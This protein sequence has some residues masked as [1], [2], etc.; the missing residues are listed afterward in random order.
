MPSAIATFTGDERDA[1]RFATLLAAR[2]RWRDRGHPRRRRRSARRS[3]AASRPL[4]GGARPWRPGR[5]PAATVAATRNRTSTG[6]SRALVG[7][8]R[9][10]ADLAGEHL[11]GYASSAPRPGPSSWLHDLAVGERE[12]DHVSGVAR[13]STSTG[14]PGATSRSSTS[15]RSRRRAGLDGGREPRLNSR[16]TAR[17]S[18]RRGRRAQVLAARADP[19][20]R[21]GARRARVALRLVGELPRL[22]DLRADLGELDL[23]EPLALRTSL[24]SS[25]PMRRSAADLERQ[26][27]ISSRFRRPAGGCDQRRRRAARRCADAHRRQLGIDAGFGRCRRRAR[28]SRGRREA[29]SPGRPCAGSGRRRG[30]LM[31]CHASP[32][33]LTAPALQIDGQRARGGGVVELG[34]AAEQLEKV[35][36]SSARRRSAAF[37]R[38]DELHLVDH[39]PRRA[40][41]AGDANPRAAI[42]ARLG[43]AQRV[44]PSIVSRSSACCTSSCCASSSRFARCAA[45]AG[46][47]STCCVGC[48]RL[49]AVVSVSSSAAATRWR[50]AVRPTRQRSLCGAGVGA[51]RER[52][53]CVPRCEGR[54]ARAEATSRSSCAISAR[55]SSAIARAAAA[56]S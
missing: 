18:R 34:L 51:E 26:Y 4:A 24:P 52:S 31:S 27:F 22:L 37:T 35:R 53:A 3:A 6:N 1:R 12:L 20:R 9:D 14:A 49:A 40:L 16:I 28:A 7:G 43:G 47:G 5:S 38:V 30:R 25:T 19:G 33:R 54:P 29:C 48:Q 45:L 50:L 2:T 39:A 42:G 8:A 44:G 10:L 56:R 17:P 55:L 21:A 13:A 46:I 41:A 15:L 36:L 23:G 32:P 11:A